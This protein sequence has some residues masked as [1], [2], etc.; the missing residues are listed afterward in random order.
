MER[1]VRE[2]QCQLFACCVPMTGEHT[3]EWLGLVLCCVVYSHSIL[4]D[5]LHHSSFGPFCIICMMAVSTLLT[6]P[7]FVVRWGLHILAQGI[8]M[9]CITVLGMCLFG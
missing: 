4:S 6:L 2:V 8:A 1:H 7:L 5:N 9:Y 3:L